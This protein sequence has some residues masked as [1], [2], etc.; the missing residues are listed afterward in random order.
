GLSSAGRPRRVPALFPHPSRRDSVM[1]RST[2]FFGCLLSL[3]LALSGCASVGGAPRAG[4]EEKPS[5]EEAEAM[6][7]MG[8]KVKGTIV[9]SSSRP[10]NHDLVTTDN[11]G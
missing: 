4:S 3:A 11:H 9:W 5:D 10:G 8:Q 7:A 6:K 2:G 1:S